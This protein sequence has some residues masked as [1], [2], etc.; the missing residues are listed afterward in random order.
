MPAKNKEP[1]GQAPAKPKPEDQIEEFKIKFEDFKSEIE[2][3]Q[4]VLSQ[5][6]EDVHKSRANIEQLMIDEQKKFDES[7]KATE[8]EVKDMFQTK[9]DELQNEINISFQSLEKQLNNGLNSHVV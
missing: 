9:I 1:S 8:D 6:F 4:E 5:Q 7:L 3:R 2:K